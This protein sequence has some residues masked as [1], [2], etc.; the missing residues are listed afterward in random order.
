M[1]FRSE[2]F[3]LPH[4]VTHTSPPCF[5]QNHIIHNQ[6]TI[7]ILTGSSS[8]NKQR[9]RGIGHLAI[10]NGQGAMTGWCDGFLECISGNSKKRCIFAD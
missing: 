4:T 9:N 1:H 3:P 2:F 8:K 6:F 5:Y 10:G 7:K